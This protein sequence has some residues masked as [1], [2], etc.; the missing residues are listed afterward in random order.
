[1]LSKTKAK[2]INYI[3]KYIHNKVNLSKKVLPQLPIIPLGINTEE[4]DYSDDFKTN[5]RKKLNINDSD[6]V[7]TYVGRLSFHAKAHHLPMYIALENAS[8]KLKKD[9][10]I[11][12][13]QTG[14]FASDFIFSSEKNFFRF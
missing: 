5:S 13:I 6:I 8:K 12:L 10:K 2:D 3:A 4:F 7:I 1:M 11:H 14:W 9:Q